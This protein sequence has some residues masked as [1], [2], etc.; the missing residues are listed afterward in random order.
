[1]EDY[2]FLFIAILLSIFGALNQNKKKGRQENAS[3][4]PRPRDARSNPFLNFELMDVEDEEEA[5]ERKARDEAKR[6]E[7]LRSV[8]AEK[9]KASHQ[10]RF[11]TTLPDRP[12]R[13]VI[14]PALKVIE[15]EEPST[16]T[17]ESVS[18]LE[19]F[20]LR[21]A[22]IYSEILHPKYKSL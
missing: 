16:S 22:V 3:D 5:Y 4:E 12:K 20:S 14:K 19:D 2:I 15:T 18:Y 21:K 7:F 1:M 11:S 9:E 6:T 17:V 13:K 8:E 10:T